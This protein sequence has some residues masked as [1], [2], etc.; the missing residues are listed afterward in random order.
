M[1]SRRRVTHPTVGLKLIAIA[2]CLIVIGVAVRK[3]P[4][5]G[6]AFDPTHFRYSHLSTIRVAA[7]SGHYP[8]PRADPSI[9]NLRV[10][11]DEAW[12]L[13]FYHTVMINFLGLETGMDKV[14]YF[15]YVIVAPVSVGGSLVLC[16]R[17]IGSRSGLTNQTALFVLPWFGGLLFVAPSHDALLGFP[18]GAAMFLLTVVVLILVEV[19]DSPNVWSGLA[20]TTTLLTSGY[21]HTAGLVLLLCLLSLFIATYVL[22]FRRAGRLRVVS[23]LAIVIQFINSAIVFN[24]YL[25]TVTAAILEALT[26]TSRDIRTEGGGT[27]I[28]G[29][30]GIDVSISQFLSA[31]DYAL[32]WSLV[33]SVLLFALVVWLRSVFSR[34]RYSN[35]DRVGATTIPGPTGRAGL[36]FASLAVGILLS[37]AAFYT[38]GGIRGVVRRTTQYATLYSFVAIPLLSGV[39]IRDRVVDRIPQIRVSDGTIRRGN[40]AALSI[41]VTMMLVSTG[42]FLATDAPQRSS[43]YLTH[44]ESEG[45]N[46]ASEYLPED[47]RVTGT[48]HIAPPFLDR[49]THVVGFGFTRFD[50]RTIREILRGLYYDPGSKTTSR[51]IEILEAEYGPVSAVVFTRREAGKVG[52]ATRAQNWPPAPNE[53]PSGHDHNPTLDRV[54]GN[55]KV[56]MFRR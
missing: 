55:G 25:K 35:H 7:S 17:Q 51:S 21:R 9:A 54:Y 48:Y 43:H 4:Y 47:D 46:T 11:I 13:I 28:P 50:D 3:A 36:V 15:R 45:T 42:A 56:V 52:V 40:R 38:Y 44:A 5:Q 6:L 53:H 33:L 29:G 8:R 22:P 27:A 14:T 49:Q 34:F 2:V 30:D 20:V 19:G 39:R 1:A 24:F 32:V 12:A 26:V 10:A 23:T 31:F 41:I 18:F 16:A 37:M